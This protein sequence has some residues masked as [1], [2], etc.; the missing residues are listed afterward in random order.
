MGRCLTISMEYGRS[1]GRT[2]MELGMFTTCMTAMKQWDQALA[3][4]P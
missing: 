4:R 3:S 1:S 2:V